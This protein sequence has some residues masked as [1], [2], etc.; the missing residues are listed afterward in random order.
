[1]QSN[2]F[3]LALL[4]AINDWQCGGDE[5]QNKARGEKLKLACIGVL[6]T[7]KVCD[8]ACYRQIALPKAGVW[9]LVAINNLTEKISSW[10]LDLN[11][12]KE[13]KRG[14][15]PLGQGFQGVIFKIIPPASSITLNLNSLFKST[16]FLVA[17]HN[18]QSKINNFANGIG[19]YSDSQ[20]EVVLEIE[21]LM[22]EDVYSLGGHSSNET[23]L[24]LEFKEAYGRPP[25]DDEYQLLKEKAG[26]DWLS[27]ESTLRVLSKTQSRAKMFFKNN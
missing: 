18:S 13:F 17:V 10:T 27:L 8:L 12:A 25:T 3:N 6:N 19:K 16:D 22:Q 20:V 2:V 23:I 4:Q 9:D 11:V 5:K 26:A 15:P 24:A 21:S 14:V 7:Y 1:M